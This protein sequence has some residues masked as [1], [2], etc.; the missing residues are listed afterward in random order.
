MTAFLVLQSSQNPFALINQKYASFEWLSYSDA[1]LSVAVLAMSDGHEL[2]V[3]SVVIIACN[4]YKDYNQYNPI[5]SSN[6]LSI[7]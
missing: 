3:A 4:H 2:F 7:D 6:P 1:S 5:D